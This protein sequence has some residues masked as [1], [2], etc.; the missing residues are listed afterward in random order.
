MVVKAATL[1]GLPTVA[2]AAEAKLNSF[3]GRQPVIRRTT[4]EGLADGLV[5]RLS[6]AY[7]SGDFGPFT[8]L[9]E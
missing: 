4:I 7:T 6:T 2:R 8:A 9:M 1:L 3:I 5:A